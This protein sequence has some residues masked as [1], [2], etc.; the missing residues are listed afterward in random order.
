MQMMKFACVNDWPVLL[1]IIVCSVVTIAVAIERS[2]Y[3]L[4]NRRDT[5]KLLRTLSREVTH[6][7]TSGKVYCSRVG[8]VLGDVAVDAIALLQERKTRFEQSF[9]IV[10]S[11]AT[12]QLEKNLSI[13]GSIAT[14]SPYLGL[15]GTVVR[16]LL[17]FGEMAHSAGNAPT[18]V[19]F[20]I[21]SALIATAFG[22]AVAIASVALNNY[23]RSVVASF[24]DGFQMLKMLLL[25]VSGE[26][27]AAVATTAPA[28]FRP[29]R[30]L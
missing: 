20:G 7:L 11:L 25:S 28:S 27:L 1:P 9:D 17:T 24:E 29:R 4:R 18:Q 21:G 23:F 16:I 13:L 8:G 26:P 12:R 10:S 2:W 19:M 5:P 22:L 15:L 14:I 6:D 3:Y 30:D